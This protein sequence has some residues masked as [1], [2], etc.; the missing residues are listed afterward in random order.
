M[1]AKKNSTR[2]TKSNE[3]SALEQ[4]TGSE[5]LRNHDLKELEVDL[6]KV[7]SL[8][9]SSADLLDDL[10]DRIENKQT[11]Q[12]YLAWGLRDILTQQIAELQ[13]IKLTAKQLLSQVS[14][15]SAMN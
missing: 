7:I 11:I 2:R 1:Q 12:G 6:E 14:R 15:E 8:L 3:P 13:K 5:F 10:G 4:L 9:T